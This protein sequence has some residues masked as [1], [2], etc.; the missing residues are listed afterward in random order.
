MTDWA[1]FTKIHGERIAT[2]GEKPKITHYLVVKATENMLKISVFILILLFAYIGIYGATTQT[3]ANKMNWALHAAE[4]CL[5]V[6]L[7]LLKSSEKR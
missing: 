7:G 2:T 3:D 1:S 4:L 5:G 6:F